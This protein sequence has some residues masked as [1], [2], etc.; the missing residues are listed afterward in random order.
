MVILVSQATCKDLDL[1]QVT[2]SPVVP[3]A[4]ILMQKSYFA[5]VLIKPL[6]IK[7]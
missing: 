1:T 7:A 5:L 3:A 4:T 6:V 2:A